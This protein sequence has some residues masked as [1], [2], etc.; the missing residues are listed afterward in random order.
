MYKEAQNILLLVSLLT[1]SISLGS[2]KD[3]KQNIQV[4]V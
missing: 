3:K 2:S 4:S 1:L